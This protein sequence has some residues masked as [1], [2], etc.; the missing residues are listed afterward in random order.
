MAVFGFRSVYFLLLSE[1]LLAAAFQNTPLRSNVSTKKI[2][3]L[4]SM[5][6]GNNRRA[7][8]AS[9]ASILGTVIPTQYANAAGKPPTEDELKRIRTGYN[10]I[11]YLLENFEQ[12]T[13][14][15]RENGGECKRDADPVRR[16]MGLRSTTDPLFQIEK[17]FEKVKYMDID[18]DYL[19]TYFEAT[20]EWNTAVNMSNSMAFIS[21]FG[22]YNPGG[23]KDEVLKYLN[24]AKKQVELAESALK[25]IIDILEV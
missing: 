12:E 1:V 24:E 18:P 21:Q 14:V 2:L 8:V 9:T 13:T 6:A 10:G 19:E 7:F 16:Y 23:G 20:E 22:E 15:C 25:K 11:K 4:Y 5:K 17:V 3:S